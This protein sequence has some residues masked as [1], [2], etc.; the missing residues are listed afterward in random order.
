MRAER[1]GDAYGATALLH[2]RCRAQE[3]PTI[4]NK[5][6]LARTPSLL[7]KCHKRLHS[8]QAI[9]KLSEARV[10]LDTAAVLRIKC[11]NHNARRLSIATGA[12]IRRGTS[13][14]LR[15]RLRLLLLLIATV[16]EVEA[17]ADAAI[18]EAMPTDASTV[19]NA[20]PNPPG[21][22]MDF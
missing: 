15:F 8:G 14:C 3:R 21:L 13:F 1:D 9:E 2:V 20:T 5:L 6:L 18:G 11:A 17:A 4:L 12:A 22:M 10:G 7:Q 19:R 16:V